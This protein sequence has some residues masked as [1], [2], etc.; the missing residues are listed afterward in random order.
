MS[1]SATLSISEMAS[2]CKR[3]GFVLPASEAYGGIAGFWDYGPRG[4]ELKNSIKQLWWKTFVQERDDV[5][6]LDGSIITH[7]TVWKASG[8]VDKF[9]DPMV[10]CKK[11]GT[12]YKADAV[13]SDKCANAN[14][15]GILEKAADFNLMFRSNVGPIADEKN[16]VY[17]RP[18]TA[19]AIFANF[20]AIAEVSRAKLPFGIAQ[21]GKAFRNE[22]AP[23]DFLFRSREFEQMEMEFFVHPEKVGDCDLLNK[24]MM[25]FEL[26]ILTAEFQAKDKKEATTM[27]LSDLIQ[28]KIF[29][30][31]WFAY[32]MHVQYN[33]FVSLGIDPKNIRL[34]Q[35]IPSEL[36][37]YAKGCVDIEYNFP[38]G[39]KEIH[40]MADRGQF[41]LTQHQTFS[42]KSMELFDEE[43]KK[44][45]VPYVA[46]EPSQG[47]DRAFLAFLFDAYSKPE[48]D[49]VILK[50]HSKLAPI[51]VAVLPLMKKD[52][53]AEKAKEIYDLLKVKF[54]S[55]Y[56][57]SGSIGK[58]YY[59]MDEVG[60]P[61]CIT[62]DYE[63]LE[64]KNK[65][66]FNTVTL[67]NRDDGKQIRIKT[68][69]LADT[70]A[71]LLANEMEF[72]EL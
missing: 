59:R 58:R 14:C 41:D 23:R 15:L 45:V 19:Q 5:F 34:R 11:C 72:S 54:V 49:H 10:V 64:S 16:I 2:F 66:N 67:R 30:N 51:K 40:G 33:W 25:G 43:T 46:C 36:A 57:E 38:F 27:N 29:P 8:H 1:A 20:R 24:K 31:K 63:T 7:P 28:K 39:W 69:E 65:K 6:G 47:V 53:L 18:E 9:V 52:G 17:L 4:T 50:L 21:M 68:K 3:T 48:E 61:Y 71:K 44:K 70:L 55:F 32:W 56:D 22:I 13:D 12:R 42:T 62:V 37:H 26:P 60:T 35:H